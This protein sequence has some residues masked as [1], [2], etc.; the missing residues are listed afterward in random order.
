[1]SPGKH[2]L[3]VVIHPR[4]RHDYRATGVVSLKLLRT[5][6]FGWSVL[7]LLLQQE[8]SR[9]HIEELDAKIESRRKLI[10]A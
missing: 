3:P 4:Y 1:M 8:H 2:H 10:L 9:S 5:P 6:R 7:P